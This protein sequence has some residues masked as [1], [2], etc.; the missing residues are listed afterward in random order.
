MRLTRSGLERLDARRVDFPLPHRRAPDDHP[1]RVE[2][3][4]ATG[5]TLF[6]VGVPAADRLRGEFAGKDGQIEAVHTQLEAS[7]FSVRL[8]RL[9]RATTMHLLARVDSLSLD[10]P[11]SRGI[12]PHKFIELGRSLYPGEVVSR[13]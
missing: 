13:K 8:P 3:R 5:S 2:V 7:A 9:L 10:D 1:W 4:D 11:R 6:A 12:E